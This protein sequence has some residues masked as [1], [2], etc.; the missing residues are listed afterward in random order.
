MINLKARNLIQADLLET[1]YSGNGL[2]R[3][4]FWISEPV[5]DQ[6]GLQDVRET[7]EELE[8][9]T[10]DVRAMRKKLETTKFTMT[11]LLQS[12]AMSIQSIIDRYSDQYKTEGIEQMLR[13]LEED[14][15]IMRHNGYMLL[16]EHFVDKPLNEETKVIQIMA[17]VKREAVKDFEYYRQLRDSRQA[18]KKTQRNLRQSSTA[19][20]T[21]FG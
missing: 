20:L 7:E 8:K 9:E 13:D 17:P 6:C 18:S 12:A 16:P 11:L 21:L 10:S 4:I 1:S 15:K 19:Q 14:G 2:L 5:E 3:S